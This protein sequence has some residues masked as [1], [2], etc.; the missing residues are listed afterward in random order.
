MLNGS[1][2][3]TIHQ[4][5]LRYIIYKAAMLVHSQNT[6]SENQMF[7]KYNSASYHKHTVVSHTYN[8]NDKTESCQFVHQN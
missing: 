1:E 5:H 8:V 6:K 4:I 3:F 7:K 2:P